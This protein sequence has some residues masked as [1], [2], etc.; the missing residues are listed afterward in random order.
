MFY[1]VVH[2]HPQGEVEVTLLEMVSE[3]ERVD[4]TQVE[5]PQ[6]VFLLLKLF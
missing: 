1:D 5:M 4:M 3:A 2:L 6:Q